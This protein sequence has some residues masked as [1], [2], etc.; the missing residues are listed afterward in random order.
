MKRSNYSRID[1]AY[2]IISDIKRFPIKDSGEEFVRK[3]GIGSD[4]D[5]YESC[6]MTY[7]N[8]EN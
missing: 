7:V 5:F 3:C 2:I 4:G 8:D 6:G 1:K